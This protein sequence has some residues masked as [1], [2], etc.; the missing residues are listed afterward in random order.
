MVCISATGGRTK[1]EDKFAPSTNGPFEFSVVEPFNGTLF[2]FPLRT[3]DQAKLQL[4][5]SILE[6]TMSRNFYKKARESLFFL[7]HVKT[8]EAFYLGDKPRVETVVVRLSLRARQSR[9][10]SDTENDMRLDIRVKKFP[11]LAKRQRF[12]GLSDGRHSRSGLGTKISKFSLEIVGLSLRV[13][14]T[15][16]GLFLTSTCQHISAPGEGK[17]LPLL[18]TRGIHLGS[19]SL[20]GCSLSFP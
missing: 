1:F 13:S 11:S 16:T 17:V 2:R 15:P 20:A 12:R 10:G 14:S 4:T 19:W 3:S 7:R 9:K 5:R 6:S 8:I 18:G